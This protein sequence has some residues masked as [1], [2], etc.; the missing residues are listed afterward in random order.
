MVER[1]RVVYDGPGFLPGVPCRDLTEE[2][3]DELSDDAKALLAA[4]LE[5]TTG[6]VFSNA[7][8]KRSKLTEAV[9]E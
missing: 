9:E 4:H 1:R 8:V 2:D 5:L 3:F 7:T 6:R